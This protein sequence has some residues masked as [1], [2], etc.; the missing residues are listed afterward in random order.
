[1]N[2]FDN[3][4]YVLNL[5]AFFSNS[6]S[7]MGHLW[8]VSIILILY[9]LTIFLNKNIEWLKKNYNIVLALAIIICGITLFINQ[10]IG[11]YFFYALLYFAIYTKNKYTQINNEKW[12]SIAKYCIIIIMMCALRLIGKKFFDNTFLYDGVIVLITQAVIALN[13]FK[14]I[15]CL[16]IKSESKIID[17]LYEHSYFVYIVHY[18]FCRGPLKI[19]YPLSKYY[20]FQV[21]LVFTATLICAILMNICYKKISKISFIRKCSE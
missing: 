8:L 17:F 4:I 10:K 3:I 11:R 7:G 18:I 9:L 1:M 6:L 16:N 14:F 15:L 19:I 13:I 2:F 12:K 20:L 5:Q 21:I